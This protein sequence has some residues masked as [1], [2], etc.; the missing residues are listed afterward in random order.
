VKGGKRLA[1]HKTLMQ[2]VAA[3]DRAA[4][5]DLITKTQ[6]VNAI[7]TPTLRGTAPPSRNPLD[8]PG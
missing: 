1:C 5:G 3:P 6:F 8:T 7:A 2:L 4:V